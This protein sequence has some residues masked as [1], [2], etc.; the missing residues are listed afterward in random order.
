MFEENARV[1]QIIKTFAAEAC[2]ELFAAYDLEL[3]PSPAAVASTTVVFSAVMGFVGQKLR[4]TMLLAADEGTLTGSCPSGG[5]LRD[6]AGE[7]ANQLVGRMK[8]KLLSRGVDVGLSTPIV[9]TGLRIEPLPKGQL[10]PDYFVS[11]RGMVLVWLEL[12]I[13]S[14][15]KL[16]EEESRQSEPEGAIVVF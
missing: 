16:L 5:R 9:W 2:C 6:W 12:E 13:E 4:G 14:G 11:S 3:R 10:Q 15:L 8:S 7:L 1:H